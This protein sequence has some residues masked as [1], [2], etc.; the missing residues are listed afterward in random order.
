MRY[1]QIWLQESWLNGLLTK[2][3]SR[4]IADLRVRG[5]GEAN[6]PVEVVVASQ[7]ASTV[8]YGAV[9]LQFVCKLKPSANNR[10]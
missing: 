5:G 6:E 4:L 2:I 7:Q 3:Y 10:A 8:S 9:D 1:D